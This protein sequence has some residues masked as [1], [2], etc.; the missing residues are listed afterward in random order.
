MTMIPAASASTRR[1]DRM[2]GPAIERSGSSPPQHTK[3][4]RRSDKTPPRDSAARAVGPSSQVLGPAPSRRH[5]AGRGGDRGQPLP[6][7]ARRSSR[8]GA[9]ARVP[10]SR[11]WCQLSG[12]RVRRETHSA[13]ARSGACTER[14]QHTAPGMIVLAGLAG[15]AGLLAGWHGRAGRGRLPGGRRIARQEGGTHGWGPP[16]IRNLH[17]AESCSV[18]GWRAGSATASMGV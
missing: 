5:G 4:V 14:C 13:P 11:A 12:Y 6:V 3:A 16:L 17:V 10:A 2:L 18:G 15:F 7:A 1:R 9:A 8:P